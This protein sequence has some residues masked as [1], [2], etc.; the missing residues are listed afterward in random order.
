MERK[1]IIFLTLATFFVVTLGVFYYLSKNKILSITVNPFLPTPSQVGQESKLEVIA[2]NLNIPWEVAIL[3]DGDFLITER[4][5]KLLRIGKDK[6]TIEVSGVK[7]I[8]EGG[9]LGLALDPDFSKNNFIYLYLT[10]EDEGKTVNRVERYSLSGSTLSER[11]VILSGIQGA[12]NHDGGRIKFGPDGYLYIG[13]GDAQ[14]SKLSQDTNSLNGK[15]LRIAKDGTIPPDNPF[16]NAVYS[17]GHRNVQGLTWDKDGNLWATEHGRSGALSGFDELNLIEKGKNYGWPDIEGDE[18][19][20]D[21]VSPVMHSG[22]S[23]TWAP[24][25]AAFFNGSIF[26][27]GLRGE[28]LYEAKLSGK[29]VS[30]LLKHLAGQYGRLRAVT[31][32]DDGNLYVLT[33]NRD[34][35]GRVRE[36][37]DKLI[38]INVSDL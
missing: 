38:R 12:A 33:S 15:I 5:G 29:S 7:H 32:G 3:P 16:G 18:K 20:E 14:N 8:G 26:F 23:E 17:Y 9:L 11:K 25:G 19:A 22:L 10:S 30:Q 31:V 13:T 6:T 28:T 36:G 2:E 34:G 35:R 4:S 27:A 24:S 37:D 1:K 21:V